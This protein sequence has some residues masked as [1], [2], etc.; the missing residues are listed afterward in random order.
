MSGLRGLGS[1]VEKALDSVRSGRQYGPESSGSWP[2]GKK[3]DIDG[4]GFD[5][6]S[7]APSEI[8]G[9]GDF[10]GLRVYAGTD[11]NDTIPSPPPEL[12]SAPWHDER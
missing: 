4:A 8:P 5:L 1:R 2:K 9:A 6:A 12:E 7:S 3:V 11:S 10:D